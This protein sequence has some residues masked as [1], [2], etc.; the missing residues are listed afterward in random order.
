VNRQEREERDAQPEPERSPQSAAP[1][2]QAPAVNRVLAMQ[3][4]LGNAAVSAMLARNGTSPPAAPAAGPSVTHHT[5]AEL[6]AMTLTEFES[7]A[8]AQADWASEPGRPASDPPLDAAFKQKLRNLL[9]FARED[10][11]GVRPVLSGCGDMTVHDL[12]ATGLTTVVRNKL[13][14]YAQAVAQAPDVTVELQP[15]TDVAR[16]QVL[17]DAIHKLEGMQGKGV[18]HAI[19]QP[20]NGVPDPLGALIASGHLDDFIAYVRRA[21]PLIEAPGMEIDSYLA[22]RSEGADPLHYLGRLRDVRNFHRFEKAALDAAV[23]NRAYHRKDKPLFLILHSNFDHN[24]AFH[25]DPN[26]TAVMTDARHL[27]LL[28]EGKETLGE[29]SGELHDLAHDYGQH[30]QISQ[31]MFAGHGNANVIQLAGTMDRAAL[32]AGDEIEASERNEAITSRPGATTE[33]D[34]LM[35]ELLANMA[36]DGS[37]RIVLNGCLTASQAVPGPL[38][39][40]PVKAAHQVQ[41]AIGAQPNLTKYLNDA[42][43]ASHVTVRG[44]NASF[45]QVSLMDASGN[46]DIVAAGGAD[47]MLTAP[48]ID[49]IRAGN[50]P[51]GAL[52]AVLEVWQADRLA[53]PPGTSAI[54]AVNNRIHTQAAS[55]GWDPTLI[56]T[57]YG[58]VSANPDNAE[59]IRRLG[60]CSGSVS[61]MVHDNQCRVDK[62]ASMPGPQVGTI[63]TGLSP[64][65]RWTGTPSI[66]LVALQRWLHEEAAKK[67]DFLTE[68]S[69]FTCNAAKKY[70]DLAALGTK[71]GEM[72]PVADAPHATNGQLK[73]ALLGARPGSVDPVCRDFLRAV[74]GTGSGFPAA[75]GIDTLLGGMGTQT[76]VEIAI[77]VRG[78]AATPP[79]GSTTPAAPPMNVDLDRD[80][81]N[82]FRV[83]PIT[84]RGA[85]TAHRLNVR[86]R[87]DLAAAIL[88]ALPRGAPINLIGTS[89]DWYAI[90]HSPGTAFVHKDWVDL[91]TQL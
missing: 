68:L 77:G 30:N 42:A 21:R 27:A 26:M 50:E 55:P 82:D 31:V 23:R 65:T 15:I 3:R 8:E 86:E 61:E 59:L 20:C 1:A 18:A 90:E 14:S 11:G 62:L 39:P 25:R 88:D 47:P 71:L 33:T 72:L 46:L 78:P 10:A 19:C 48:K 44:A 4:G 12:V 7:F 76:D 40:D 64:T 9:E 57:L 28:I 51:Q 5:R 56:L 49:Y 41:A 79:S 53:T 69:G 13:R 84:R 17:G 38:D 81:T 63:F 60:V 80:G 73:L 89:G 45:D 70:V 66:R 35:H 85:V 16:A 6:D 32:D 87:P 24:G 58:I 22:L 67:T 75:L 2:P 83:D 29:I 74:V 36:T 34:A 54:D 91:R 52:R 37:A 43:A